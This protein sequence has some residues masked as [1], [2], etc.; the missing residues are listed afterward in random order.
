MRTTAHGPICRRFAVLDSLEQLVVQGDLVV[1]GSP[2]G[3][4][5]K[6]ISTARHPRFLL[7]NSGL[8]LQEDVAAICSFEGLIKAGAA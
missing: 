8:Y 1:V 4:L 7:G 6:A 3:S 2:I 5:G